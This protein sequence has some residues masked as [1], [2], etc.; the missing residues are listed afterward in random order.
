MSFIKISA[1]LLVFSVLLT[2]CSSDPEQAKFNSWKDTAYQ[3]EGLSYDNS[4]L[5]KEAQKELKPI[6]DTVNEIIPSG[7]FKVNV[8][9]LKDDNWKR[10]ICKDYVDVA[11][12]Q[13]LEPLPEPIIGN[14]EVF[15]ESGFTSL[16]QFKKISDKLGSS[17]TETDDATGILDGTN[18]E[19]PYPAK[20]YTIIKETEKF[21]VV[22]SANSGWNALFWEEYYVEE[23]PGKMDTKDFP[24]PSDDYMP[25]IVDVYY[26]PACE[27]L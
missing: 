27:K 11:G 10:N 24:L 13:I 3:V 2:G 16:K 18:A 9:I 20:Q 25:F 8:D 1:A 4:D 26:T 14:D 6:L 23:D 21:K 7:R 22:I 5:K 12:D 17:I 19:Y 15:V